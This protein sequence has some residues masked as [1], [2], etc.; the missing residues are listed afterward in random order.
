ML[1][2]VVV[3]IYSRVTKPFINLDFLAS[4]EKMKDLNGMLI[5]DMKS[6]KEDNFVANNINYGKSIA[7]TKRLYKIV[8]SHCDK[9]S[10]RGNSTYH[11]PNKNN[12]KFHYLIDM[13]EDMDI[14]EDTG[15]IVIIINKDG[16]EGVEHRDHDCPG[17]VSEFIW[18]RT[19][20][21]K[22]FYVK[23]NFDIKRYI[24]CNIM[25]F[26]DMRRHNITPTDKDSFSIRVNGKFNKKFREYMYYN[27]P[28]KNQINREAFLKNV[29]RY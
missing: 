25:W 18:I 6:T 15:N 13:I 2:I 1:L 8:E 14:F 20:N 9:R 21:D 29:D 3:F 23:D 12:K 11:V 22:L 16:E 27:A 7:L 19:N 24:N 26:D 4:Q 10:K 17:W 5:N 28:F